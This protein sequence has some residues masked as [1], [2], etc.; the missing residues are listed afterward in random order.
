MLIGTAISEIIE[1]QGKGMRFDLEEM[2]SDEAIWYLD[3][4][5]RNDS[6]GPIESIT[7]LKEPAKPAETQ[8]KKQSASR[9]STPKQPNI[10]TAKI[11]AIEEIDEDEDEEDEDLIPYEKPDD[12]ASDSDDDPTLV[13]RNKP[14]APV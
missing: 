8:T 1:Q 13:Q 3:L 4:A 9:T 6:V 10:R 12:D 11:V 5:K 7:S 14:T 2:E